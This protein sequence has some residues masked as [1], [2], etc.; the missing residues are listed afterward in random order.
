[1]LDLANSYRQFA[2]GVLLLGL[3]AAVA[4]TA[5]VWLIERRAGATTASGVPASVVDGWFLALAGLVVALVALLLLWPHGADAGRRR[6]RLGHLAGRGAPAR[7]GRATPE[8]PK[9]T[10]P[11]P[12]TGA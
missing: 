3:V 11:P 6:D 9:F 12:A 1:M 5:A 2:R 10:P 7:A 4:A 8:V